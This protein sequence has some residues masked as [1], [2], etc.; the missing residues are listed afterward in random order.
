MRCSCSGNRPARRYAHSVDRD[1]GAA[2]STDP[3]RL[4]DDT[5]QALETN[6]RTEQLKVFDQEDP[7]R[8]IRCGFAGCTYLAADEAR[9]QN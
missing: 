2:W 9:E 7:A 4:P 6:G 5:R 1:Q 8:V 3:L